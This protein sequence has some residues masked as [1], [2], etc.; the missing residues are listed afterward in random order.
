MRADRAVEFRLGGGV[1]SPS[2]VEEISGRPAGARDGSTALIT[3]VWATGPPR[4][5]PSR[6]SAG[7]VNGA[8][9]AVW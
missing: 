3:V 1:R 6:S 2:T 9:G 5:S 4:R 7:S 8:V